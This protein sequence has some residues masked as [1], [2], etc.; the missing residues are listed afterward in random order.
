MRLTILEPL[1]HRDF[2]LLWMGQSVSQLG[3]SLYFIALPFQIL[4]LGG[5]PLQLGLGFTASSAAQVVA[6]LFGGALV[7]RLPRRRVILALDL[8]STVVVA[9]VAALA[10][11]GRL[12]IAHIYVAA[13]FFGATVAFYNP[14]M[15]AIM[16]ELVPKDVLVSGNALRSLS[17]Q[18]ARV[19]GPSIGGILVATAGPP[20]AFAI[21]AATFAFSFGVFLLSRPPLRQSTP[22][23]ALLREIGN[24]FKYTFSV[25]WI[26]VT[27]V[28]FALS[29]G[30]YFA[31]ATVAQPLL[32]LRVLGGSAATFGLIGAVA[33]SGQVVGGLIVG[34]LHIRRLGVGIYLWSAL[35]GLSFV[36]YGLVPALP[37][38]LAAAFAF[39]VT[40]IIANTIWE[41]AMQKHVPGELLG[42]VSSVDDFGSYLIGP[43][44]PIVAAAAIERVGPS[45][46]YLIGGAVSFVFWIAALATVRSVRQLE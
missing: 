7:D 1:K 35:L 17:R 21:D 10:I 24:G 5:T 14:A 16:P 22:R 13:A 31:G 40:L 11:I 44:A 3:N 29:N 23:K 38:V 12:Q 45:P 15:N 20:S 4:K 6:V 37:V 46:I 36:A 19:I 32:V 28:G 41:T 26:W 33:A 25:T 2:R 43:I 8:I 27:I 18:A 39:G 42:R 34:N 9:L 30:F